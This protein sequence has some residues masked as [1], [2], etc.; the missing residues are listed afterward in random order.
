MKITKPKDSRKKLENKLWKLTSEYVRRRYAN[1][2][3]Y[4]KCF[5]CSAIKKWK[6]MDAGHFIDKSVC[7]EKLIYDL[8]NVQVQ[9]TACNRYKSGN[10]DIYSL[11]LLQKYGNGIIEL[12]FAQKAI[13]RKLTETELENLIIERKKQLDELTQC[14]GKQV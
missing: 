4:V 2:D 11:N 6:E 5:T 14:M 9:C 3:G 13:V 8:V 10:K 1:S 12:L 7:G